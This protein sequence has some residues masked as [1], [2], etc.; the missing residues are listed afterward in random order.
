MTTASPTF[1]EALAEMARPWQEIILNH[2]LFDAL[3][4]GRIPR[5]NLGEL[6][7]QMY[8]RI[9]GTQSR[10]LRGMLSQAE[11]EI[12]GRRLRTMVEEFGHDTLLL[13]AAPDYD[14][15]L[16]DME[17]AIPTVETEI[18]DLYSRPGA[19][20]ITPA[21]G[22]T[23][24]FLVEGIFND[25][26]ARTRDGLRR[27]YSA[28]ERML[29]FYEVH[30]TAD[31]MHGEAGRRETEALR[32]D[33]GVEMQALRN[34]RRTLEYR[35][36]FY[37]GILRV[38]LDPTEVRRPWPIVRSLDDDT[39][40]FLSALE[41]ALAPLREAVLAHPILQEIHDGS[42]PSEA[43]TI[44]FTQLHLLVQKLTFVLLEGLMRHPDHEWAGRYAHT[45]ARERSLHRALLA[46]SDSRGKARQTADAAE[47]TP[48][49]QGAG[50]WLQQLAAQTLP[51][52]QEAFTYGW[53]SVW[54]QLCRRLVQDIRGQ[55]PEHLKAAAY[56]DFYARDEDFILDRSSEALRAYL[57]RRADF[58]QQAAYAA[59]RGLQYLRLFLDGC[60][61]DLQDPL[62][63]SIRPVSG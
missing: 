52:E 61:R 13:D 7:K 23:F 38:C 53:L 47:S 34:I 2:P 44:L 12:V 58:Q 3:D 5:E 60:R 10:I 45:T 35:G 31:A 46:W 55:Y 39:P 8:L 54:P 15:T 17:E 32:L 51:I 50:F 41:V 25:V 49:T 27:R 29:A 59:A 56:L 24:A 40:A 63:R 43:L 20:V 33:A 57:P 14:L 62:R 19:K 6:N 42:A 26:C 37:D 11:P 48:E 21:D 22:K 1:A 4:S 16:A 36:L 30:V 18:Q 28:S 9:Q